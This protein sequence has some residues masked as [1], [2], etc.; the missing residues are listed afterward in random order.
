MPVKTRNKPPVTGYVAHDVFDDSGRLLLA[1]GAALTPAIIQKLEDKMIPYRIVPDQLAV[2]TH[3][4]TEAAKQFETRFAKL[5]LS[6]I[7]KASKYMKSILG[8]ANQS[9]LLSNH[10]KVLI[11]GYKSIYSHSIN[12]SLLAVAIA[13][14]LNLDARSL[15]DLALG[16]LYHDIGKIML[17]AA[18]VMKTPGI[19]E[20]QDLIYQQHTKIGADLLAA[21]KLGKGV[22]LVALQHHEKHSGGGYPAGLKEDQIHIHAAIVSVANRF[23]W[24]TSAIFQN[25]VLSPDEAIEQLLLA[26]GGDFQPLVVDKFVELFREGPPPAPSPEM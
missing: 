19:F 8:E 13:D 16:A 18:V 5:D 22:Y 21:D 20:R 23:D 6:S 4:L 12:V 17:P 1:E 7:V 9:P 15:R 25:R 10:L 14:K 2:T 24:L 11:Q 3:S 26:K